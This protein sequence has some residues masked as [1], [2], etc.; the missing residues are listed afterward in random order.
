MINLFFFIFSFY[1]SL[2]SIIGYGKIF[3]KVFLNKIYYDE[4]ITIYIGFYGIML[5][6]LLSLFT[7]FFLKHNFYHNI[8]FHIIG[9]SYF[10]YSPLKEH[11]IF[12]KNIFY[13]SIFL[14]PVLFISKTHDDFSFYHYPFTK[15][16]TEYHIIFGMGNINTGYNF[17]SSL[18]FLNSTFYL[19]FIKLYS[20]HFTI[21]SFLLFFNYFLLVKIFSSKTDK[22]FKY[23]YLLTF[24]FFNLSFNR[25]AEFGMDKPGQLLIVILIISLFETIIKKSNE[26]KIDNILLLVPLV[27]L[28][29]STKTYFLTYLL[30]GLSIFI[31]DKNYLKNFNYLIFSKPFLSFVLILTLTFSHHFVATG[32]LISPLPILCF[33]ESLIWARDLND[34]KGLSMWVEQWSK[35]GASPTYVIENGEEYIKN[36]N[37]LSNWIEKYFIVKFLDQIA[38]LGSCI[39]LIFFLLKKFSLSNEKFLF[40]REFVLF[41]SM[42]VVIFYIWFSNHPTLRYGGYSAFYLLV[43]FPLAFLFYKLKN[44]NNERKKIILIIILVISIVDIKNIIRINKE[45]KRSDYYNFSNFP[46]FALREKEYTQKNFDTGLTM[47]FA[48]HCWDTPSPCGEGYSDNIVTYEKNGYYFIQIQK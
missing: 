6:T 36:F 1:V 10:F 39:V 14:L 28:C 11:K 31:I 40:K 9:I 8:I 17:L 34:V 44:N 23:F 27:G 18:F 16:L 19:P 12:F 24:I 45:F 13:I 7:S 15:F 3:Q 2:I 4:D 38:I 32:C 47:Y 35:A 41:L 29:I 46:F 42:I 30:L 22:F 20:F 25:L 48:H 21:I 26:K 5:M 33:D 37:W 43:S